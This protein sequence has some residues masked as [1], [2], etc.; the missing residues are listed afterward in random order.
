MM[1]VLTNIKIIIL[2][3][4]NIKELIMSKEIFNVGS[5]FR[6]NPMSLTPGGKTVIIT[7]K[8]G[9]TISYRNIKNPNAYIAKIDRNTISIIKIR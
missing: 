8:N 9:T 1:D 3:K 6:T 2:I 7:Y 4:L 5:N